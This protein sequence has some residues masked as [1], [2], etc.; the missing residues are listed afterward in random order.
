MTTTVFRLDGNVGR[1]AADSRVSLPDKYGIVKKAFDLPNYHKVVN[2]GNAIYGFAGT[3]IFYGEFLRNYDIAVS[4]PHFL[5]DA[6]V[7]KAKQVRAQFGMLKYDGELRQF[8]YSPPTNGQFEINLNSNSK[9]LSVAHYAIGSGK[10]SKSYKKFRLN[11]NAQLPIFKIIS[12]NNAAIKKK[13]LAPISA[14]LIKSELN[15]DEGRMLSL[16]CNENGGDVF[17]GG[18]VRIVEINKSKFTSKEDALQQADILRELDEIAK[19]SGL[20][21]TSPIYA[22]K[23]I[24]TLEAAGVSPISGL[25]SSSL[26]KSELFKSI[27]KSIDNALF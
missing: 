11:R 12:A 24:E 23:E 5:L 22:Q 4:D 21:C 20:V 15:A 19:E 8:C 25:N 1:L 16:A 6:L 2:L 13:G 3:N 18:Q 10:N 14:K 7:L 9:T 26:E 27:S 17:T